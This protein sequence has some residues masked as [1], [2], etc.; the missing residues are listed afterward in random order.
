ME[1]CPWYHGE[2]KVTVYH[3]LHIDAYWAGC[4]SWSRSLGSPRVKRG[5]R[6]E[7][8]QGMQ[9]IGASGKATGSSGVARSFGEAEQ[10]ELCGTSLRATSRGE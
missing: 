7:E 6:G 9:A 10:L 1:V 4:T 2:S 5:S 8:N 3:A